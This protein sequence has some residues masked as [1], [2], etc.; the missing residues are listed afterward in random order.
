MI[1]DE[2]IRLKRTL[3]EETEMEHLEN[4]TSF[5]FGWVD[6]K[7]GLLAKSQGQGTRDT[8]TDKDLEGAKMG[9]NL[10]GLGIWINDLQESRF[11]KELRMVAEMRYW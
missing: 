3:K 11:N 5:Y 8:G 10:V 4:N 6:E 7:G 1:T 2:L 9:G